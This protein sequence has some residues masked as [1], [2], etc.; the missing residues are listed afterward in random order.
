MVIS[1]TLLESVQVDLY[2]SMMAWSLDG[3]VH[4]KRD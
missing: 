2:G 1:I 4:M 3:N